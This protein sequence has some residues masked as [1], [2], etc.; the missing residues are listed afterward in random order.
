[1]S[2]RKILRDVI[3]PI[4]GVAALIREIF[5]LPEP[6]YFPVAIA[7]VM[8]GLPLDALLRLLSL[9]ESLPDTPSPSVPPSLP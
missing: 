8:I 9:R 7:F 1:M 4:I 2:W 3:C 5:I 6:R